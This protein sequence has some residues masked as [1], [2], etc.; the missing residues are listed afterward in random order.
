MTKKKGYF[1]T[2][3]KYY[4]ILDDKTFSK[5]TT[6]KKKLILSKEYKL[7]N[8]CQVFDSDNMTGKKNTFCI[9]F[10]KEKETIFLLASNEQEKQDWMQI[11][12]E[13]VFKI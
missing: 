8:N 1:S 9:I 4:F 12:Q 7:S 2:W 6:H 10:K 5:Y 3:K 11:L 13:Q